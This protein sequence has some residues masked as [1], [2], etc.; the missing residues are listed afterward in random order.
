M[1][2]AFPGQRKDGTRG[3]V[4]A[5]MMVLV[6]ASSATAQPASSAEAIVAEMREVWQARADETDANLVTLSTTEE[7]HR[8]FVTFDR[9]R[10]FLLVNRATFEG[11]VQRV[12]IDIEYSNETE[13]T[14]EWVPTGWSVTQFGETG[15]I[16]FDVR[17]EVSRFEINVETDPEEFDVSL[18]SSSWVQDHRP[19]SER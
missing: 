2:H 10:D 16:I 7:P 18:P 15:D 11:E 4:V 9:S 1:C 14:T 5:T 17:A 6:A 13:A 19:T 12:H 3:F 8:H